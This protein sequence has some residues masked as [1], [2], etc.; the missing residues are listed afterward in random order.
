[1]HV[2]YKQYFKVLFICPDV[3]VMSQVAITIIV[4]GLDVEVMSQVAITIIVYII[5]HFFGG[6]VR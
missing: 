4:L 1:L 3:D 5:N 2:D 6:T